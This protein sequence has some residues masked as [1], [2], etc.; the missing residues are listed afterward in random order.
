MYVAHPRVP[1][2]TPSPPSVDLP[3]NA[4]I[5]HLTP[6]RKPEI[7]SAIWIFVEDHSSMAYPQPNIL[8]WLESERPILAHLVNMH[9]LSQTFRGE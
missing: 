3:P 9:E 1:I 4:P 8:R 5:A 7:L 2:S 6:R